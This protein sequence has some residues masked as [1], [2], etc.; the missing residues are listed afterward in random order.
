MQEQKIS[1]FNSIKLLEYLD[2]QGIKGIGQTSWGPTTF[3]IT[4]SQAQAEAITDRLRDYMQSRSTETQI[5]EDAEKIDFLIVKGDNQ[6][7]VVAS[8]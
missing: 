2:K 8:D 4:E 3:V 1:Q 5:L 6:G 7:A